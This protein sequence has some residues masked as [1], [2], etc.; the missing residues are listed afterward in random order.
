MWA[1]P[2]STRW[3]AR[4]EFSNF[5]KL[6]FVLI[7][8][9]RRHS[10]SA[11]SCPEPRSKSPCPVPTLK[12]APGR[13]HTR[14]RSRCCRRAIGKGCAAHVEDSLGLLLLGSLLLGILLLNELEEEGLVPLLGVL[15]GGVAGDLCLL[16]DT[17]ATEALLSD[18]ALDL[19]RLVESLVLALDLAAN[20]ILANVVLL[21][22]ESEGS[23][24][25]VG[26][27]DTESAGSFNIGDTLDLLSTLLDNAA[28]T[29]QPQTDLL[30]RSPCLCGL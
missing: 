27:L 5:V 24:N 16:D 2:A 28:P 11:T 29:T 7:L 22:V 8:S 15:G 21:S 4:C 20:N 18:E 6:S 17:L 10:L 26:S 25:V 30:E 9:C 14:D 13:L 23:H 19:W 12:C 3:G 1:C